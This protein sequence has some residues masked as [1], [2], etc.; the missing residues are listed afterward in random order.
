MLFV[1]F[2]WKE[3]RL[4]QFPPLF[5]WLHRS[6][7]AAPSQLGSPGAAGPRSAPV[8]AASP[9]VAGETQKSWAGVPAAQHWWRRCSFTG[10]NIHIVLF[11]FVWRTYLRMA[12]DLKQ[13]VVWFFF[14]GYLKRN[15]LTQMCTKTSENK[16]IKALE[17]P[18][19]QCC[20][21]AML[22]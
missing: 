20:V 6:L 2:L 8:P 5:N 16:I 14:F 17:S 7:A 3:Q 15:K 21:N 9:A 11:C 19:P 12:W 18:H 10:L 22:F 4:G 1:F 13:F